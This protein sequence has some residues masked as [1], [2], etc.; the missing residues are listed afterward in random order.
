MLFLLVLHF[1]LNISIH[2][3]QRRRLPILVL[4]VLKI[5]PTKLSLVEGA[6]LSSERLLRLSTRQKQRKT[7]VMQAPDSN[8]STSAFT[9]TD[10]AELRAKIQFKGLT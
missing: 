8:L 3:L 10:A 5:I 9:S 4:F 7:V 2:E 6:V 1:S